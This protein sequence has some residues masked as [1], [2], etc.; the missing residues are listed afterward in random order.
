M[1][2]EIITKDMNIMEVVKKYPQT[3][4]VFQKYRMGCI[5][6]MAAQYEKISDIA[7]V[8]GVDLEAFVKDLNEAVAQQ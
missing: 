4:A 5:G 6:C 8:H 1:S 7:V 2:E 3:V